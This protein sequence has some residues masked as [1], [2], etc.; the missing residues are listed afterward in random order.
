MQKNITMKNLILLYIFSIITLSLQAQNYQTIEEIDNICAELG[1]SSDEEIQFAVD[2]IVSHIGLK[3]NFELLSCPRINNA[4]AKNIKDQEGN[5]KRY[6]L[7]D[8]QFIE[9][10]SKNAQND[11]SAISILA[12]EIG[13]HLNGHSLNNKG[14][15][16]KWELE[17]DEFSGFV[18]AKMG[19]SLLEAQSAIETLKYTKA[20]TTHPAKADRLKQIE[21]GWISGGGKNSLINQPDINILQTYW[22]NYVVNKTPEIG[23]TPPA[24]PFSVNMLQLK[25]GTKLSVKY[26]RLSRKDRKIFEE[27]V[28]YNKL[29]CTGANENTIISFSNNVFIENTLI[30]AGKYALFTIPNVDYWTIIF[31]K[32]INNWGIP[33]EWDNSKIIA[34]FKIAPQTLKM[35]IETF[36]LNFQ[37]TA[38]NKA[39]LVL[40]LEHTQIKLPVKEAIETVNEEL[41]S[42]IYQNIDFTTFEI[43][44]R[45]ITKIETNIP[46]VIAQKIVIS[47]TITI[48]NNIVQ[49]GTYQLVGKIENNKLQITIQDNQTNN[50][51]LFVKN[52][53]L[54]IPIAN[55]LLENNLL[56]NS[57]QIHIELTN[58]KTGTANL[59]IKLNE[60]S[61]LVPIKLPTHER[62]KSNIESLIAINAATESNYYNAAK[63]YYNNN[64]DNNKS[65]EWIDKA[66]SLSENEKFWQLYLQSKIYY[67]LQLKKEAL[68]IA[69]RSLL[70]AKKAQNNFYIN[71]IEKSIK[72]WQN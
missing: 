2:K 65:K 20:T 33:T 9:R 43:F 17:A 71:E 27:V 6:I 15:N 56:G 52:K 49:K 3:R 23:I 11:W 1:F 37:P 47:E 39:N 41:I 25:Y 31:Y 13:H 10:I 67:V 26:S 66:I 59:E 44:Y 22:Q 42:A 64:F 53:P 24:S 21:I 62:V 14:S 18:L 45:N 46:F 35:P 40:S 34:T 60:K 58:F 63:Y 61:I 8:T 36:S 55:T 28:P 30:K 54:A 69:E 68:N 4:I 7:Y 32:D 12:H 16:H 50:N 57:S 51:A 38:L 5:F 48:A 29:W 70:L 72:H 19:A